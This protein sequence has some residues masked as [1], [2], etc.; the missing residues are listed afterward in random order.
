MGRVVLGIGVC[1]V[2][3]AGCVSS[4]DSLRDTGAETPSVL[5]RAAHEPVSAP[6]GEGVAQSGPQGVE[7]EP[8]DG[9]RPAS[10]EIVRGTGR[11][12]GT[13]PARPAAIASDDEEGIVLNFAEVEVREV[14]Q[15]VLGELLGL[16]YQIGGGVQGAVTIQTQRPLTRS[17]VLPVFEQALLLNGLAL[18]MLNDFHTILTASDAQ[19]YV[20]VTPLASARSRTGPGFGVDVVPLRYVSVTEMQRLLDPLVQSQAVAQIDPARNL[21]YI[22]GTLTERAVVLDNIALLDV[23]WMAGM[24]FAF[25]TPEYVAAQTLAQELRLIMGGADGPAGPLRLM[26]LD[27]LNTVLAFAP[28]ADQL[29][30]LR[31]WVARLDRPGEGSDRRLYIYPVQ[32]GRAV[33]LAD[34]LRRALLTGSDTGQSPTPRPVAPE[35]VFGGSP[36]GGGQDILAAGVSS[37]INVTADETNNALVITATPGEFAILQSALR[38][39]DIE[40]LQVLLEATIVEVTLTDD[41]QYGLQYLFRPNARQEFVLSAG[42]TADIA[43]AFPGFAYIYSGIDI[44]AILDALASVT[45]VE[46]L[47]SPH[48]LVLNNQTA[49]LQVGNQVPIVTGQA[50]STVAQ[51]APIVNT[52][53]YQDTGII[54]E[55]TPRVNQGGLVMMDISQEVSD[56][57]I[58]TTSRIDSPT[59]QQRRIRSTVAVQDRE[60]IALGGLILS[61]RTDSRS[62]IPFLQRIPGLGALFRSTSESRH[63][64]ELIVLI[65]PRVVSGPGSA[66]A[67]TE[68]LMRKL[69]AVQAAV[70]SAL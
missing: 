63:R 38:R 9:G 15:A 62:G 25:Y 10:V 2:L 4:G 12:L 48:L 64:T 51:G 29:E 18:V 39:L 30:E 8:A 66:R 17:A 14:A 44:T 16:N 42:P 31:V 67:I 45:R 5:P 68:E 27:R 13:L 58:T 50:V 32:N 3:V 33:D 56:I 40:P 26:T 61:N 59:F 54:L 28:E 1:L 70:E 36:S 69:P 7:L 6:P 65:T 47:S 49:A 34:V 35:L 21:M 60:T 43:P 57:L 37:R 53:E 19:R 11:L 23:S 41:L 20:G 22:R 46:V 55:V 24:S 52:I